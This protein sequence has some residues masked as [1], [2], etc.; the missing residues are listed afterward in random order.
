MPNA[1][2][3]AEHYGWYV[4]DASLVD[5]VMA[6]LRDDDPPQMIMAISIQN[7]GPYESVPLPVC[8]GLQPA[9]PPHAK[10]T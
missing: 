5:R 4:S 7:H 1:F 6:E 8:R 2:D 3:G 9:D 10:P